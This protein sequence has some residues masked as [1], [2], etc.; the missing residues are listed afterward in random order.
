MAWLGL[1]IGGNEK[2]K[3]SPLCCGG[4]DHIY[5]IHSRATKMIFCKVLSDSMRTISSKI[6]KNTASPC[7]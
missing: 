1:K 6:E 2:Q 7:P 3:I 4:E 5:S